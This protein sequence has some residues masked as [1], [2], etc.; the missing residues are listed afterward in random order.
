ME[1]IIKITELMIMSLF[2][3]NYSNKKIQN[4]D[5]LCGGVTYQ[6]MKHY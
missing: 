2:T 6:L 4:I 3:V 5:I 1:Y